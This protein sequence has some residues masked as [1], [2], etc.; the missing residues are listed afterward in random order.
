MP[1]DHAR[2]SK[3]TIKKRPSLATKSWENNRKVPKN[4]SMVHKSKVANA[5]KTENPLAQANY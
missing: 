3:R 1:T 4:R 2:I 5:K